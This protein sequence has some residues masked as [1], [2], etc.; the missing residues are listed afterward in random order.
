MTGVIVLLG[1]LR[2]SL[3]LEVV[4]I[5]NA[6]YNQL[7]SLIDD[8]Y[9]RQQTVLNTIVTNFNQVEDNQVAIDGTITDFASL[10]DSWSTVFLD[11]FH[12]V[13]CVLFF[14][15][16]IKAIGGFRDR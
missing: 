11:N 5:T 6:Q 12:I 15:F 9:T 10:F 1:A 16:S 8:I 7:Y 13:I 4:L 14:I 3:L 2:L